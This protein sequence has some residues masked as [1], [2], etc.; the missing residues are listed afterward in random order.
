MGSIP[1][2]VK[3]DDPIIICINLGK[4]LVEFGGRKVYSGGKEGLSEL[5]LVQLAI[6]I[7]INALEKL[8]QL[9]F[10]MLNESAKFYRESAES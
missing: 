7:S 10:R 4:E 3:R 5:V 6:S 1:P 2:L 8:P 9:F